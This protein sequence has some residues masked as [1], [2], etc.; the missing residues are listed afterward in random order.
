MGGLYDF[1]LDSDDIKKE[2]KKR[3]EKK[4]GEKD[5]V[6]SVGIIMIKS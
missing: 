2:Y 6:Y 3:F 4:L 5:R 1:L